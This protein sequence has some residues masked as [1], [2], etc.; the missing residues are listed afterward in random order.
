MMPVN[1][2][3]ENL[4]D[5]EEPMN[6]SSLD[7]KKPFRDM[8]VVGIGASAGGLEALSQMMS[9]MPDDTN[10]SFVLAQHLSPSYRSMLVDLLQKESKI[11]VVTAKNGEPLYPNT[12][13]VCPPS[14]NIEIG[15]DQTIIL[16]LTNDNFHLPRP[17]VDMLF[18]SLAVSKGEDAIGIVL[19]GTGSDGARGIRIIKGEGGFGI[20]QDPGTAKY[21]G[22]PNA[23]INS[24][25]VDLIVPASEIGKELKNIA[26]FPNKRK[27]EFDSELS[28]D[29]YLEILMLLKKARKVDFN[30]YK[31]TTVLRR[32][33]RRMT[34]L[35]IT[36]VVEYIDCLKTNP[37]ELEVLFNDML[38]GVTSFFRDGSAFNRLSEKMRSYIAESTTKSLRVWVPACAT[39]EEPY[40]IAMMIAEI[41]GKRL[42]DYKVQIF[43]TDVDNKAISIARNGV[44]TESAISAIP[45]S[46]RRKYFTV[47]GDSFQII[48]PIKAMVIF[49]VQDVTV[50]PPFLRLD[51]I[52]CR[53]LLIYFNLELQRRVFPIFHYALNTKGLLFLGQSESIGMF[54]DQFRVVSANAKIY[55]AN[56]L[57]QKMVPSVQ[58]QQ[59]ASAKMDDIRMFSEMPRT[60]EKRVSETKNTVDTLNHYIIEKLK[61]VLLPYTVLVNENMDIVFTNGQNPLIE[62]PVGLPSNNI[63]KNLNSVLTID[64]RSGIH[65]IE[66]GEKLVRTSFQ[67]ISVN[68]QDLWAR[69]VLS[70]LEFIPGMGKLTMIFFQLENQIDLPLTAV[71]GAKTESSVIALEQERQLIKAKEQLQTVIEESET[72]NEEMQSLNEELQS[73]N[74]ELQSSNEE[75][76]TTNEELQSTNEEL[77]TAYAELKIAYDE[78]ALQQSKL[79]RLT[80]Q[81]EK[82]NALLK[83]AEHLG[84]N[85]SFRWILKEDLMFW[86]DGVYFLFGIDAQKYTPTYEAFIGLA[87]REDR[88]KLEDYLERLLTHKKTEPLQFRAQRKNSETIWLK[89]EASVSY[90]KMKQVDEVVGNLSDVTEQ[91]NM[92]F[93]LQAQQNDLV[94]VLD[95]SLCG[96]VGYDLNEEV[97]T[98]VNAAFSSMLNYDLSQ[99]QSL[100]KQGL[101]KIVNPDDVN[102]LKSV[103]EGLKQSDSVNINGRTFRIRKNGEDNQFIRFYASEVLSPVGLKAKHGATVFFSLIAADDAK[104]NYEFYKSLVMSYQESN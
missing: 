21:D 13:Y 83:E 85:G 7:I 93:E 91:K 99:M 16:T 60:P 100:G 23:A 81:L 17:S 38:I 86:S 94:R 28:K 45:D 76:E 15:N 53:N 58:R 14:Y 61:E 31:K 51:L 88:Q 69:L 26:D 33:Q 41:L 8:I 102:E 68:N 37:D 56:F 52:S 46:I 5:A 73:S 3:N 80:Q 49:S 96:V 66:N 70:P 101:L 40:S 25:N 97:V 78:R 36:K 35:K 2:E 34:A 18:E 11:N 44:Y 57:G 59:V 87:H 32:I 75:L 9:N 48:K 79:E 12:L 29:N 62:R 10:M 55:E 92:K 71:D 65:Q 67:K 89:L 6:E 103:I 50:D 82:S 104:A 63:F 39:G 98:Y 54:Q 95:A 24:G 77:Q 42:N 90:D 1:P 20:V 4:S 72:S 74:E 47:N 27:V 84:R 43:A 22:M 64:L 19:S 30:L